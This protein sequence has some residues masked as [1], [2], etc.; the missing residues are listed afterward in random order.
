[1]LKQPYGSVPQISLKSTDCPVDAI[2]VCFGANCDFSSEPNEIHTGLQALI[3]KNAVECW[4]PTEQMAHQVLTEQRIKLLRCRD[5]VMVATW[6]DKAQCD[7]LL[8]ETQRAYERL[9]D[10][11][12]R[13]GQWH[14]VRSWNYLPAIN[15]GSGDLENYKLFCAGRAAA[16]ESRGIDERA[17][18][19]ASALGT[20]SEGAV[21]YLLATPQ[22][23]TQFENPE[24]TS[25]YLYP[26]QY[27]P[28][29]PTFARATSAQ[30]GEHD[31]LFISGTASVRGH[32][33]QHPGDAV[34]QTEQTLE[35]IAGLLATVNQRTGKF[36]S[37]DFL[38]V[39]LRVANDQPV[40]A[41]LIEKQYPDCEIIYVKAD[42]C[43]SELLVEI[44]G[45]CWL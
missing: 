12:K 8:S 3:P 18:A 45:H 5:F 38:K 14:V 9:L 42:I 10:L 4:Q 21:F 19:A 13:Q 35:N 11:V 31:I 17:F 41:A 37:P 23:G 28:R 24:Q 39:Y 20:Q 33:S 15:S 32:Q 29:S 43:R 16:Y 2:K 30:I 36:V 1:M 25:A 44:D 7:D 6:L 22:P 26:R 34:R 40:V 27:G